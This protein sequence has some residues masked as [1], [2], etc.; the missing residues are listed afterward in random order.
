MS[1]TSSIGIASKFTGSIATTVLTVTAVAVGTIAVGQ[2]IFGAGV[3]AGTTI[4]SLGTGTGGTGTYNLS[5]SMTVASEAM[6]STTRNY[7]TITSWLAAFANGGWIGECYNDNEFNNTNGETLPLVF[8][9]N[10]SSSNY[11]TLQCAAGQSYR[12]NAN[13]QTNRFA[14]VQANGVGVLKSSAYGAIINISKDY[15]TIFGLQF[16]HSGNNANDTMMKGAVTTATHSVLDSCIAELVTPA[17]ASIGVLDGTSMLSRNCLAVITGTSGKGVAGDYNSVGKV[18][19]CTVLRTQNRTAANNAFDVKSGSTVVV[20]NCAVFGFS[21]FFG[22][23]TRF[24]GSDYNG[25]DL[26]STGVGSNNVTSIAFSTATFKTVVDTS[27]D[28][29]LVTGSA[30]LDVGTTDTT[31]IPAAIDAVGTSRPQGSA[32][33]IGAWELVVASATLPVGAQTLPYYRRAA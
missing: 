30:L 16:R 25:T 12:D 22:D 10:T 31:D 5:A 27:H 20:K 2:Q 21:T 4:T 24:T 23:T 14:Y 15:V 18:I 32:W 26:S 7:S 13:V 11:L 33:D 17:N 9:Q 8:N 28:Y 3:T 19:N 1:T 6:T 29:K